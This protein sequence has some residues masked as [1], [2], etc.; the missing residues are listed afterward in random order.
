MLL[1]PKHT[2]TIGVSLIYCPK[3]LFHVLGLEIEFFDLSTEIEALSHL[4]M[5]TLKVGFPFISL[6]Q[7]SLQQDCLTKTNLSFRSL[8]FLWD[9]DG[10]VEDED[11][12]LRI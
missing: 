3:T 7:S 9:N 8:Y 11:K 5:V 10:E 4:A 2:Q 6:Y 1:I 12:Q